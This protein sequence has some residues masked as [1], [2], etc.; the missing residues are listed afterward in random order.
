MIIEVL[1]ANTV[2]V[3]IRI[4]APAEDARIRDIV[5]EEIAE[6][7]DA[8]R[9]RPSLVSVSIQPMDGDD[10]A[11][12]Q[13]KHI[14]TCPTYSIVAFCPSATTLRPWGQASRGSPVFEGSPACYDS[15]PNGSAEW[16]VMSTVSLSL[17]SPRNGISRRHREDA[18][19]RK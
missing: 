17:R 19:L 10:T 5:R 8:V 6:P 3:S 14:N 16:R 2:T 15:Q 13:D 11:N 1:A 18:M 7:V 9:R 4:V 12:R